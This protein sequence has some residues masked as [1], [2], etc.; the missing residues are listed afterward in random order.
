MLRRWLRTLL[1][2]LWYDPVE[3]DKRDE[4]T[5]QVIK[6]SETVIRD[7]DHLIESYREAD[8]AMRRTNQSMWRH[9]GA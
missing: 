1:T 3:D 8:K 7:S 5:A 2:F 6:R 9:K 4:K